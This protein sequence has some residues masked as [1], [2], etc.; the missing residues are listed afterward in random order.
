MVETRLQCFSTLPRR[1]SKRKRPSRV[2]TVP[3][4]RHA[5]CHCK[6]YNDLYK[7]ATGV[8]IGV[9]PIFEGLVYRAGFE[10]GG[11]KEATE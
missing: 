11:R 1:R 5:L 10:A 6:A 9:E 8:S 2:G 4:F 7:T 3:P